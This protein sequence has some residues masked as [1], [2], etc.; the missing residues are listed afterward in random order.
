MKMMKTAILTA[1]ILCSATV[2]AES[3]SINAGANAQVQ[4][5]GL[6]S[7]IGNGVKNGVSDTAHA[8][9]STAVKATD[10]TIDA[11]SH[12]AHK[13]RDVA[14]SAKDKT[15]NVAEKVGDKSEHAWQDTKQGTKNAVNK[16]EKFTA[17]EKAKAKSRWA[18]MK[19]DANGNQG[20]QTQTQAG[21]KVGSVNA[22]AG[23]ATNASTRNLGVQGQAGIE[24]QPTTKQNTAT[25]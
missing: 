12:V 15:V 18:A 11:G 10:A 1:S 4:S 19:N 9:H 22:N 14:V 3:A 2:F 21:V 23:V 8:V 7:S 6:L 16:T 13:T 17:E 5:G 20:I 25:N 24:K